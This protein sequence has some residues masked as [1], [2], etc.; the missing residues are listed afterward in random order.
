VNLPSIWITGTTRSGKT[1]RLVECFQ[2]WIPVRPPA[3]PLDAPGILALAA[4]GDNRLE[5]EARLTAAT[6]GRYPFRSTTPLGFFEDEV[7]LF[8]SLLI[9]ELDLKAQFPL[10]LAPETEQELAAQL[11]QPELDRLLAQ[12]SSRLVSRLVRRMLD[13]MQLAALAGFSVAEVPT[14]LADGLVGQPPELPLPFEKVGEMLQRWQT[15][16]LERGFVTY[17]LIAALY[18]QHL[19]PHPAYQ[20][21]LQ[22]RYPILLA[23]DVDEYPAIAR[24]LFE[25]LLK[26]GARAVFTFNPR[27]AVRLGLGAD[28]THLAE[29]ADR[30]QVEEL[31]GQPV[32]T[33][34]AVSSTTV[35]LVSN[36]V[37]IATLPESFQTIQAVSR[38]QLLQQVAEVV[39]TAIQAEA[40]QPQEI[41]IIAPGFDAI[42]RYSLVD[43]FTRHQ[44]PV[45]SLNDQRPLASYPI[46]R[47]L[48]TLLTLIY[49]G[50][51]RLVDRDAVAEMLVVLSP[52]EEKGQKAEGKQKAAGEEKTK[53]AGQKA[54]EDF[55][56]PSTVHHSPSTLHSPPST[57]PSS[58]IDPVRAGLLADYCFVPHPERPHLLPAKTFPRWDRL[59]YQATTAYDDLI[60]WI[61]TQQSQL[62]QRL[63]PSPIALLDRA[64]Q[65]F[66][67]GGGTLPFNQLSA[68][69]QLLETAQ[70]YWEVSRRL[71]QGERHETPAYMAIASLIQLLRS[72]AV[73]A[74]PYPVKPLGPALNAITLANVFQY[75]SSRRA[76]RWQFWLDAGSPRWLNGIDA[77]FGAPLF[78][79]NW[80]GR[81]W[82]A[83]DTMTANEQRLHRILLDLLGRVDERVYLCHSEL[84]TNGQEQIGGLL[85]L[86]NATLAPPL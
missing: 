11:W 69:R 21:H 22:Q 17:G 12:Q 33:L 44:I 62:E 25:A 34:A 29:L 63:I 2:S 64:I 13:L 6:G 42:A 36:P 19:L 31:D 8:W 52:V 38:A 15:W 27:G 10:R 24:S 56:S 68:L 37:F 40:I 86:V 46:I 20:T 55:P 71:R 51:G 61:A 16:C 7:V 65:H 85:P 66:L 83:T 1:E 77:L 43:T 53:A 75:R 26:G 78:L 72:G 49:P 82:T 41:A 3:N 47:A 58:L 84:A 14:I 23:D 18:G 57:P 30:C 4:I 81:P 9:Q 50:L 79:Q 5:L 67:S 35:E 45:E 39:I 76:H 73:T 28:P 70:H 32:S 48:L 59:G 60:A 54:G 74:N 80:T